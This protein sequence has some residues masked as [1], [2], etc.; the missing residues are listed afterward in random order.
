VRMVCDNCREE[1]APDASERQQLASWAAQLRS[2]S[3]VRGHGCSRC[4][5]T[6]YSG[7]KGIFE[8]FQVTD[9]IRHMIFERAPAS[10]IRVAARA[11]G[12]RTLRE[13]G[14]RKVVAGWTTLAEVMRVTMGDQD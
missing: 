6:G 14:M 11:G 5:L 2:G 1:Y 7:R 9:E 8:I 10:H 13:D 4:S 12:M 3:L